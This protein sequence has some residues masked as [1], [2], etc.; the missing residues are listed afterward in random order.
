MV[1][2]LTEYKSTNDR[3]KIFSPAQISCRV[4]VH[5]GRQQTRTLRTPTGLELGQLRLRDKTINGIILS[6][7]L[8]ENERPGPLR[9]SF[10]EEP[11]A[12]CMTA[13]ISG[14]RYW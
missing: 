14:P 10:G 11:H 13:M 12:A 3:K 6:S 1:P 5:H 4:Q 7:L 8:A 9:Q 2:S